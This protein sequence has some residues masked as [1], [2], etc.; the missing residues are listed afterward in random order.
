VRER[1]IGFEHDI[2]IGDRWQDNSSNKLRSDQ[3]CQTLEP[4]GRILCCSRVA[5]GVQ[6][7]RGD[8]TWMYITV[9]KAVLSPCR[10]NT[11]W[12]TRAIQGSDGHFTARPP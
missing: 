2:P 9:G 6:M 11:F 8:F 4:K 12:V 1:K 7:S 3:S 5:L 10:K